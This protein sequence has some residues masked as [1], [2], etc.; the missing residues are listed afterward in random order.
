[1]SAELLGIVDSLEA[2]ILEASKI[3][4]SDN[5]IIDEKSLLSLIDKIR[6]AMK[7]QGNIAVSY[8]HLTL[9]TIN[10]V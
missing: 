9:P 6:I 5:I 4:F 2:T 10:S 1:M 7:S 3:P 8:T